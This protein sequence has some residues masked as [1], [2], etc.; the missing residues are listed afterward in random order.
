MP[1][2]ASR[3]GLLDFPL[4]LVALVQAVTGLELRR[5]A[6][7]TERGGARFAW[8]QEWHGEVSADVRDSQTRT[9][10]SCYHEGRTARTSPLPSSSPVSISETAAAKIDK[11]NREIRSNHR[12]VYMMCC[13]LVKAVMGDK[14]LTSHDVG[15]QWLKSKGCPRDVMDFGAELG[16]WVTTSRLQ[17]RQDW[18][19]T[20]VEDRDVIDENAEFAA[21]P[22]DNCDKDITVSENAGEGR[23]LPTITAT[24]TTRGPEVRKL[25]AARML[26]SRREP[27]VDDVMLG[28]EWETREGSER[29]ET[30]EGVLYSSGLDSVLSSSGRDNQ[31]TC[32]EAVLRK[33]W[34]C[35]VCVLFF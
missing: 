34:V 29:Y 22:V 6:V 17:H 13:V 14:F 5:E 31:L 12:R 7:D 35:A 32:L 4:T 21:I 30:F 8:E 33:V 26:R 24:N 11:D 23:H 18:W 28:Q 15:T 27:T 1:A 19:V 10:G 25:E 2:K 16:L 9:Q 3:E 20:Q